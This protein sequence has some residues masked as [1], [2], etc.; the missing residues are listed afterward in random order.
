MGAGAQEAEK[1]A[2]AIGWAERLA[3]G[4]GSSGI[5]GDGWRSRG[6]QKPDA[7][8]RSAGTERSRNRQKIRGRK[9]R[10]IE[11]KKHRAKHKARRGRGGGG[12][13]E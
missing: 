9:I 4:W 8:A 2:P 1:T 6:K 3:H 5:C 7:L 13:T 12:G 11:T 10:M